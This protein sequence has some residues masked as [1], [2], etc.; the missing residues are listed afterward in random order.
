MD[1]AA[2]IG[3]IDE[4]AYRATRPSAIGC[5]ASF[6]SDLV[7]TAVSISPLSL[8]ILVTCVPR[9]ESLPC[10]LRVIF[11]VESI[12]NIE[13]NVDDILFSIASSLREVS[14]MYADRSQ[15]ASGKGLKGSGDSYTMSVLNLAACRFHAV[16]YAKQRSVHFSV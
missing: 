5:S 16:G 2:R 3:A 8:V 12:F 7:N 15:A 6:D 11:I 13:P 14:L 4:A 10:N 1:A 9:P